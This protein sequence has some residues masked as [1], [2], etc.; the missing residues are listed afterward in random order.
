MTALTAYQEKRDKAVMVLIKETIPAKV[1]NLDSRIQDFDSTGW[2]DA[3]QFT[4]IRESL[5]PEIRQYQTILYDLCIFLKRR[6]PKMEDGHNSGVDII[7]AV[8]LEISKF[9]TRMSELHNGL[10]D[11]FW[12]SGVTHAKSTK[13]ATSEDYKRRYLLLGE[14][15]TSLIPFNLKE[16]RDAYE[17]SFDLMS[18]NLDVILCPRKT[19]SSSMY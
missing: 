19:Q 15:R 5:L 8:G 10:A 4:Y 17:M 12:G 7:K 3:D 14:N 9:E 6:T 13:H 1:L 2:N 18:K 16:V 11:V